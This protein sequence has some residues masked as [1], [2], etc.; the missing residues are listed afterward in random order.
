M[1]GMAAARRGEITLSSALPRCTRDAD[2]VPIAADGVA[3]V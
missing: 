2:G 3:V 1:D